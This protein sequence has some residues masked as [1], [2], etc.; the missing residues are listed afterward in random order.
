MSGNLARLLISALIIGTAAAAVIT[1]IAS[2]T[3]DAHSVRV[4]VLNPLGTLEPTTALPDAWRRATAGLGSLH[5]VASPDEA[6]VVIML[7]PGDGQN[8]SWR[9]NARQRAVVISVGSAAVQKY[10][11]TVVV[12]EI[13]HL[14]CCNVGGFADGHWANDAEAGLMNASGYGYDLG[15]FSPREL[16]SMGLR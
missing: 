11:I 2:P 4:H 1:F 16:R 15:L 10:G 14:W 12:H 3:V 8:M 7:L 6:N 5:V 13:G 9:I